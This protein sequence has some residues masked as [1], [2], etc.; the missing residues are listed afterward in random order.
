MQAFAVGTNNVTNSVASALQAGG[1]PRMIEPEL[2]LLSRIPEVVIL[3]FP[4]IAKA[5]LLSRRDTI[6]YIAR[7]II[8]SVICI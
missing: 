8:E 3:F 2:S 4:S 1:Q 6:S 5:I 7:P